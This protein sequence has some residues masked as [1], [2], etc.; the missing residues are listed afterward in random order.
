ME[1]N[2]IGGAIPNIDHLDNHDLMILRDKI[3]EKTKK[4]P[5]IN[6]EEELVGAL[7]DT[8]KLL[9]DAYEDDNESSSQKASL[10]NAC[11]AIMRDLAKTQESIHNSERV[12]LLEV[13]LVETLIDY[14]PEISRK[15]LELYEKRLQ[16][17]DEN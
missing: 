17:A 7:L 1:F 2:N 4:L 11:S 12:K 8:K 16:G 6:L 14:S 3:A 10:I 13:V 5:D 15:F 9:R